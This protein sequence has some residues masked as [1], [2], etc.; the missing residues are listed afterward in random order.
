MSAMAEA[1]RWGGTRDLVLSRE[2]REVPRRFI[3]RR[4]MDYKSYASLTVLIIGESQYLTF[5]CVTCFAHLNCGVAQQNASM[6]ES[7]RHIGIIR[8]SDSRQQR[9]Y[10][11][12]GDT[13]GP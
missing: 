3:L 8:G 7:S 10:S 12:A 4:G 5:G 11:S 6:L 9:Y 13:R 2:K 1:G